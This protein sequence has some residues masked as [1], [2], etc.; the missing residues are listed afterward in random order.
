MSIQSKIEDVKLQRKTLFLPKIEKRLQ[1]LEKIEKQIESLDSLMVLIQNQCDAKHGPYYNMLVNDAGMELRLRQVSTFEVKKCLAETKK[2]LERLKKRFS[3]KSISLQVFGMAGSGKSTFIQSVT[4]L[5]NDVVLASEGGHCT[6]VSSFIY[7]SDHFETLVYLYT[8][9][10][11]LSIFNKSLAL[12][13][14]KY[15]PMETP[16]L[17]Q[18]F[19]SIKTFKLSDVGLPDMIEKR[20]SVLKYVNN[21][22]LINKLLSGTDINGEP[23]DGARKDESGRFII[24]ISNPENVQKWV[25]QH[26]GHHT[27]DPDY[28]A[29]LN[30]LAVDH[31][32]IYQ[33]FNYSDA[34]DIVLMDNVGLGDGSSDV[35][36]EQH[37][38]QA[39]ADN[40][41]AVILLYQPKANSGWRGEE[42]LI[43]SNLNK[44]R[45]VDVYRAIERTDVNEVYLLLNKRETE[46]NN[47]SKDCP[48]VVD[49][50]KRSPFNRKE[51]IL[52]ANAF[53]KDSV[54]TDAVEPILK[55]LTEN[56]EKIDERKIK[57]ANELGSQLYTA[58]QELVKNVLKV[59]SGSMKQG[60]NEM[61]KFLELYET[62]LDYS[63]ELKK[64]DNQYAQN[65]DSEC[66]EVQDSIEEVIV[67]LTKLIDKPDKILVDV[68]KGKDATNAIFEKYVKLL[69]NRIYEAF[70]DVNTSVLIPLQNK[71]KDSII[72]ILFENAK[73]GKIPL[74][75]YAI[76]EGPSQEWLATFIEE[77]VEKDSYPQMREML[78][79]V[80]DYQLNIQGLI[81]YHVAKCLNTI[82]KH[83]SEFRTMN[84]ITGVTDPQHAKKIWSEIVSRATAI[85][86]KMRVWRD[87]FSLIPSHS[88]YAR[89]SMFRDMMVDDNIAEKELRHFY[90]E[91][92][93]A[94]WREEFASLIQETE[95]FGNWNEESKALTDLC[96]KNEFTT[97]LT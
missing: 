48:E 64:L 93:M 60:S 41:D 58:Y 92:R 22:D 69:R 46:G 38:Y 79:F 78:L 63:N 7:N 66:K 16:K 35:S 4:G 5:S 33:P 73:F 40:S 29:Y 86:N 84:P 1:H 31:V 45:F 94:I 62:D 72:N 71:V 83:N 27:S 15:A 10:E 20:M 36:T 12:L 76:E 43:I 80:L 74:Q 3:R 25:A 82:D 23:L 89:I 49:Y 51:T 57:T 13:Q 65:K 47:N 21:F 56:L 70:A 90:A 17:L 96:V 28:I 75:G 42:E 6:G 68:E 19:A 39:I 52:I 59:L 95:A 81:E 11:I 85:Q 77:K 18:D 88:F 37:M 91:N 26:N 24:S 50:Y 55:Q 44:I 53:Y 9:A 34:G 32:D 67:K 61:K 54:R 2:E 14:Q 8:R 30:Y 87:D 97:K